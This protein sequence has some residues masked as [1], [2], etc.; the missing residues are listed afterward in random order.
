MIGLYDIQFKLKKG[1]PLTPAQEAFVM[2]SADEKGRP[3]RR[4][5]QGLAE[6]PKSVV[7]TFLD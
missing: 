7:D 4:K 1:I 6:P 3:S 2:K 5:F